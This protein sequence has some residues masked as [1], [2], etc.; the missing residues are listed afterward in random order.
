MDIAGARPEQAGVRRLLRSLS[1]ADLS[2]LASSSM[3]PA[4]SIAAVMGLVVAAAGLGAPLA[5][6]ISTIPIAF[7]A[8]GFMRLSEWVPSVVAAFFRKPHR[9]VHG[10]SHHHRILFRDHRHRGSGCGVLDRFRCA[11]ICGVI[12]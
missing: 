7:I 5:L 9:L 2:V 3:A 12:L 11:E 4:Y 6:I 1:L 8:A 10:D